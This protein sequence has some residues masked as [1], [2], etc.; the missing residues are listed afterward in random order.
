MELFWGSYTKVLTQQG[1]GLSVG[2]NAD[3]PFSVDTFDQRIFLFEHLL[4]LSHCRLPVF[5]QTNLLLQRLNLSN[6]RAQDISESPHNYLRKLEWTTW[7]IQGGNKLHL[8]PHL[9][10]ETYMQF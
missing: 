1:K 3:L 8:P 6:S 9:K 2:F 4:D 5:Q 10:T 7:P